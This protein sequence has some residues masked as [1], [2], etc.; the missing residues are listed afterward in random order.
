[1]ANNGSGNGVLEFKVIKAELGKIKK[2]ENKG[3]PLVKLTLFED[4]VFAEVSSRQTVVL[5]I[6]EEQV[7]AWEQRIE[8]NDIPNVRGIY[9]IVP[10]KPYR[11]KDED[12]K[13][14][15]KIHTSMRVF[16]RVD[17]AGTPLEDP[18]SKAERTIEQMCEWAEDVD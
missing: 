1:M 3:K 10:T 15:D 11:T 8:K 17:K 2:G 12:G 6:S 16:T 7:P 4:D 14:R 18:K 9:T 13:V 5:F